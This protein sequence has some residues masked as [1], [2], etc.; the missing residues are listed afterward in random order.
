M[1]ADLPIFSGPCTGAA[2]A[3]AAAVCVIVMFRNQSSLPVPL[4]TKM[5]SNF[6]CGA[7]NKDESLL[8]VYTPRD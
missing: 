1:Q 7:G 8:H 2:A 6:Y 5:H 4:L 3:A